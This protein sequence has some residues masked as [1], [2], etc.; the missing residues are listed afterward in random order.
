MN[1]RDASAAPY[2]RAAAERARAAA[3]LVEAA[4]MERAAGWIEQHP[5]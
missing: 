1:R 5:K 2:V 3:K 4:E